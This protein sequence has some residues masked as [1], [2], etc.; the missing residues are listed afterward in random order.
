MSHVKH[1]VRNVQVHSIGEIKI[2]N[3]KFKVL[4]WLTNIIKFKKIEFNLIILLVQIYFI[5]NSIQFMRKLL[6]LLIF[7]I[8]EVNNSII[9]S[10]FERKYFIK[11]SIVK[12]ESKTIYS[13]TC[14]KLHEEWFLFDINI[15]TKKC[16]SFPSSGNS[17]KA[18]ILKSIKNTSTKQG[19]SVINLSML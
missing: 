18:K 9:I 4:K 12:C 10:F 2:C 13:L 5:L 7:E 1:I 16:L 3:N 15:S 8:A 19:V 14:N 11:W 6:W 17:N